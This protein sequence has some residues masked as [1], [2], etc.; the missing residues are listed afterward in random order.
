M[1]DSIFVNLICHFEYTLC[2]I[3]GIVAVNYSLGKYGNQ[4]TN[5]F[6]FETI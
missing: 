5:H 4:F 6:S 2:Q 3:L 1:Q